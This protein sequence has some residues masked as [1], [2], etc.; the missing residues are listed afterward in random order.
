MTIFVIN[1]L[2]NYHPWGPREQP[3][4]TQGILTSPYSHLT[5]TLLKSRDVIYVRPYTWEVEHIEIP[6]DLLGD[7]GLAGADVA[8]D[9]DDPRVLVHPVSRRVKILP[10]PIHRTIFV[11][12]RRN[13]GGGGDGE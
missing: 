13:S 7:G 1:S 6:G 9:D 4:C 5:S 12:P 3:P 10:K 2:L 11:V 8:V